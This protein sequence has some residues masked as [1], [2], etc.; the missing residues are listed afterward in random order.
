MGDN[1]EGSERKRDA[2]FLEGRVLALGSHLSQ[3]GPFYFLI[4]L[5][6]GAIKKNFRLASL[7]LSG[8]RSQDQVDNSGLVIDF[9]CRGV[10]RP[11]GVD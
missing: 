1:R 6:C 3:E 9:R 11:G 2:K 5:L 7:F 8:C 4:N 10:S